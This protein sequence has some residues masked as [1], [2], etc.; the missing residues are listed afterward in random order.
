MSSIEPVL[1]P[2]PNCGI[3]RGKGGVPCK[4]CGW[5]SNS[6]PAISNQNASP[7]PL[8]NLSGHRTFGNIAIMIGVLLTFG[9]L[10]LLLLT[11]LIKTPD[12]PFSLTIAPLV[13]IALGLLAVLSGFLSF[14]K[15]SIS[16]RL[17]IFSLAGVVLNIVYFIW[18][19]VSYIQTN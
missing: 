14:R 15:N 5:D 11:S 16:T 19:W 7:G 1:F 3:G 12:S 10:M 17:F 18:T 2:C 4:Q 13:Q 6:K 9:G 8:S